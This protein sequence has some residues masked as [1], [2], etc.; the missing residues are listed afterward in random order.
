MR[1]NDARGNQTTGLI[2]LLCGIACVAL[3]ITATFPLESRGGGL[4]LR[5]AQE[6]VPSLDM[7]AFL[8]MK[9]E[10]MTAEIV[11]LEVTVIDDAYVGEA[12][13]QPFDEEKLG[14]YALYAIIPSNR[15]QRMFE[16]AMSTGERIQC[17]GYKM[18]APPGHAATGLPFYR[19]VTAKVYDSDVPLKVVG[20]LAP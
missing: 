2:L 12:Y 17:Q 1:I 13:L 18:S 3:I 11:S 14:T 20:V 6:A 8:S 10:S 5:E 7:D 16:L 19:I 9:L 15:V 4:E